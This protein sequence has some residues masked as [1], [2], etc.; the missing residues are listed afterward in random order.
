M[1]WSDA[2]RFAGQTF[3]FLP[4]ATQL[5]PICDGLFVLYPH[6]TCSITSSICSS[7]QALDGHLPVGLCFCIM[8]GVIKHV[9][10]LLLRTRRFSW[11]FHVT[12]L[13]T[14]FGD[15]ASARRGKEPRIRIHRAAL[16]KWCLLLNSTHVGTHMHAGASPPRNQLQYQ[17]TTRV[18]Q[19]L[20][21]SSHNIR[22]TVLSRLF[23]W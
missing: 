21:V 1:R 4:S 15:G 22:A 10:V 12:I 19:A 16:P 23:V 13:S 8:A 20:I 17:S 7:G 6:S 14:F 3:N 11:Y 5:L 2:P 18:S 9:R